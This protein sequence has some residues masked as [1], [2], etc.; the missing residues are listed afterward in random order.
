M[1]PIKNRLIQFRT[2]EEE[3]QIISRLSPNSKN[4][5]NVAR[6]ILLTEARKLEDKSKRKIAIINREVSEIDGQI[7]TL[8]LDR[9]SKN[10]LIEQIIK[11]Q[12]D[13]INEKDNSIL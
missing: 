6:H 7:E 11:K 10:A 9:D 12:K 13:K 8:K 3:F 2:T 4:L 1:K 5:S